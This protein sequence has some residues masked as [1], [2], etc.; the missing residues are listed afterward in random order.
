M[1]WW[2]QLE[3]HSTRVVAVFTIIIAVT[4][5]VYA[6]FAGLQWDATKKSAGAARD[7]ADAAHEALVLDARPWVGL[8]GANH[9]SIQIAENTPMKTHMEFENFGKTPAM[10]EASVNKLMT[11]PKNDPM[12]RFN[13]YSRQDAGPPVTL[14][15]TAVATVN[16]TTETPSDRGQRGVLSKDGVASINQG[17]VLVFIYGSIWYSDTFKKPHRTD[18]CLQY[19]P[20]LATET[21]GSFAACPIHNYA[22]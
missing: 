8:M 15:P 2:T 5:L 17:A 21:Q 9:I 19:I 12:P 4:G 16:G 7:S 3:Q 11:L 20:P 14:M 6:V 18:Y 13:N 22:N 10:D 1:G